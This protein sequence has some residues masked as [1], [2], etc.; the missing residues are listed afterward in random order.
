MSKPEILQSYFLQSF[1]LEKQLNKYFLGVEL[2]FFTEFSQLPEKQINKHFLGMKL[3]A[4]E[5]PRLF[6][7]GDLKGVYI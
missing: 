6:R 1:L 7:S 5:N 3:S 4:K 2:S